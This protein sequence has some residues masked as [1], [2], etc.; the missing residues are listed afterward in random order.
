[1]NHQ[2]YDIRDELKT[3]FSNFEQEIGPFQLRKSSQLYEEW[4]TNAGGI[5][6]GRIVKVEG[7]SAW[8]VASRARCSCTAV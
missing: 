6:Q 3:T 7:G 5:I 1:M 2:F 8:K 4:V